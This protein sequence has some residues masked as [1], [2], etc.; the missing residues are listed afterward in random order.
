MHVAFHR[1]GGLCTYDVTKFAVME[2]GRDFLDLVHYP[3]ILYANKVAKVCQEKSGGHFPLFL[4]NEHN[5][6]I[7]QWK[8]IT[9]LKV[10]DIR[11]CLVYL[12]PF[13]RSDFLAGIPCNHVYLAASCNTAILLGVS[14]TE[15]VSVLSDSCVN[16]M[17]QLDPRLNATI[18]S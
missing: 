6:T 5:P 15:A 14:H 2:S 18:V 16:S 8:I 12:R 11:R 7:Y 3:L 13:H 4:K 9:L 10:N 1:N 17:I